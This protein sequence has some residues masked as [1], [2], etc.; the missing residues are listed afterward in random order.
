[1]LTE[2]GEQ[3][4][5]DRS[6]QDLGI[7]EAECSLQNCVRCGEVVSTLVDVANLS[8]V[9]SDE[10]IVKRKLIACASLRVESGE[11]SATRRGGN[12]QKC[13]ANHLHGAINSRELLSIDFLR[14]AL[15]E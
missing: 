3:I 13:E 1:V 9:T 7:P 2:C 8:Q 14:S 12:L 6:Q 5:R 11:R 4:E 10:C 15:S